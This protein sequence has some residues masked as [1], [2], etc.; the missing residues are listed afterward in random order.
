MR[1]IVLRFVLAAGLMGGLAIVSGCTG[2]AVGDPC[3]PEQIPE[4]GFVENEAYIE[5]GSVQCETRVCL[6]YRLSG[7]PRNVGQDDDAPTQA[8]VDERVFCSCRCN[9]GNSDFATCD[10]PSG[11]TCREILT[12]GDEGFRGSYCIR[13]GLVQDE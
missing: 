8:Q 12:L 5:A 13:E 9:A 3:M 1:N 2:P 7:D 11:F 10:C 4:G 6:V